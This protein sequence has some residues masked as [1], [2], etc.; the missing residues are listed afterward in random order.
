MIGILDSNS[1]KISLCK[2]TNDYTEGVPQGREERGNAGETSEYG[3]ISLSKICTSPAM[4]GYYADKSRG[5]CLVFDFPLSFYEESISD[6]IDLCGS[7]T[8]LIEI[9]YINTKIDSHDPYEL[10]SRKSPNWEHEG[11]YRFVFALNEVN[12]ENGTF[13]IDFP[14]E[15]LSGII[16]GPACGH[17]STEVQRLCHD[18]LK[19]EIVAVKATGSPDTYDIITNAD[20]IPRRKRK[21]TN[22]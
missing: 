14:S 6:T 7:E 22:I 10:L 1:F 4:W 21:S 8:R 2:D 5:V 3:Y 12:L 9:E 15:F 11:E 19:V 20:Q 13:T 16:L 18:K 17:P